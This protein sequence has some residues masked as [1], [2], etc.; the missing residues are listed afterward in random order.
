[1][2]DECLRSYS[3]INVIVAGKQ[4]EYQWLGM[5]EAI[6]HVRRGVGV[7]DW[8]STLTESHDGSVDIILACCGDV[9]TLE[10]LAAADMLRYYLPQ[11]RV[12][13]VNVVNLLMLRSP[14]QKQD[15]DMGDVLA[16]RFDTLSDESFD[17]IFTKTCPVVFVHHAYPTLIHRLIY[18][19]ANYSN[20]HVLGYKEEGTTTTPFDMCVLNGI[21]RFQIVQRILAHVNDSEIKIESAT[22]NGINSA[23]DDKLALHYEY[24]RASGDDMAE[25]KDWYWGMWSSQGTDH[26]AKSEGGAL[27][28]TSDDNEKV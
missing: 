28:A 14:R 6:E 9:P 23:M 16:S 26:E 24:I 8:A 19:R 11:L 22:V 4:P 25:V 21:S 10:S 13:F 15:A 20:F 7:W 27:F 1:V 18:K 3:K 17:A 12:R 5:E 2:A